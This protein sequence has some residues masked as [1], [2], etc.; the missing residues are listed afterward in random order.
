MNVFT[1]GNCKNNGKKNSI[2]GYGVLFTNYPDLNYFQVSKNIT[3]QQAELSAFKWLFRIILDN[4]DNK[5]YIKERKIYIYSDSLYSINCVT[6]WY[7]KWIGNN[8]KTK[9]NKDVKNKE[10]IIDILDYKNK[11]EELGFR[12][13]FNHVR[14]HKDPPTI[15]EDYVI[16][17]GNYTVDRLINNNINDF[18]ETEKTI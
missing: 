9:N 17:Y 14:S 18:L 5:V 15:S 8:W 3:N 11:C 12:F 7:K 10:I 4:K 1:D 2:G 16:W 6:N 13:V